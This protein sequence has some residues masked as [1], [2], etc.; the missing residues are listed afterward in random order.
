MIA[1]ELAS[2]PAGFMFIFTLVG[3]GIHV[4]ERVAG[5]LQHFAAGILLCTIGTELIP[6]M[7][8]ALGLNMNLACFIGFFSGVAAMLLLAIFFPEDEHDESDV[9]ISIPE[10][11]KDFGRKS[12]LLRT[13][14]VSVQRRS[15]L[16]T[17]CESQSLLSQ[18]SAL[19]S[20]P[21]GLLFAIAV[22]SV[23]DGLLIGIAL[24]AG[25]SAGP[26]M[27]ASL[28][29]EMSFLGLTLAMA[30]KG[31]PKVKSTFAALLGP[32]FIILGAT[33]GG[34]LSHSFSS[35][36]LSLA[37]LLSFGTSALLYMVAE[38][39]LLE[40][41]EKGEHVWWVDLQLYTGFFASIVMGKFI[42]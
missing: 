19:A 38:E 14:I 40:A 7:T 22:D 25:P 18:K 41:H 5:S 13:S 30:L 17:A 4:P 39:L 26:M 10:K 28:S 16:T 32:A 23:M 9:E 2:V 34:F 12:S 3:L 1:I 20:F 29:V 27:A 31:Q 24:A 35:N 36:P 8:G 33:I 21:A 11:K 37:F 6:T 15:I 42:K